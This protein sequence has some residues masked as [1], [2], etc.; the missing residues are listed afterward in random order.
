MSATGRRGGAGDEELGGSGRRPG[1]GA[2]DEELGGSGRRPGAGAGD[3]ELGGSGRR[4]GAGAGDE[5]LGGSGRRP[6]AG[7]GEGGRC[8]RAPDAP[9]ESEGEDGA[10]RVDPGSEQ[11]LPPQSSAGQSQLIFKA[12]GSNTEQCERCVG[13][14]TWVSLVGW[15]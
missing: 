4:P 1:G 13:W 3:E 8:V 14:C 12:R 15:V 5:E 2:G 9:E 6:G 10:E 7:A 11:Q